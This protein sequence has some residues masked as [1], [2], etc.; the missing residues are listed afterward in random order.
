MRKNFTWLAAAT[1]AGQLIGFAVLAVAARKLGPEL[2]GAYGFAVGVATYIGVITNLGIGILGSRE[3]SKDEDRSS[4]IFAEVLALQV[5]LVIAAVALMIAGRSFLATSSL[6]ATLM[7]IAVLQIGLQALNAG[8]LLQALGRSAM[9][10]LSL[11][12]GQIAYGLLA[13][14]YLTS[15][16]SGIIGFAWMNVAGA[17]VATSCSIVFAWK[18][19]A[20]RLVRPRLVTVK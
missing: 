17:A 9:F 10:G 5:M 20:L 3:V 4:V 15:G 12:L 2:I 8:W 13:V 1:F 18:L 6:T 16:T 19:G 14:L 11:L 7:T